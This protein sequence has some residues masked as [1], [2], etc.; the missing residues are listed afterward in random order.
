MGEKTASVCGPDP[1]VLYSTAQ[2]KAKCDDTSHPSHHTYCPLFLC[3]TCVQ[4]LY[5]VVYM[6]YQVDRIYIYLGWGCRLWSPRLTEGRVYPDYPCPHRELINVST[7][8]SSPLSYCSR[9]QAIHCTQDCGSNSTAKQRR[10]TFYPFSNYCMTHPHAHVLLI[11]TTAQ[12]TVYFTRV[13]HREEKV[14]LQFHTICCKYLLSPF[15]LCF[16]FV[17]RICLHGRKSTLK[18]MG[19]SKNGHL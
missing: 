9:A 12:T 1:H 16:H 11:V 10:T 7:R 19:L 3:T 8:R 13:Y 14:W 18:S 2:P 5:T 15:V 4:C 17:S 6:S